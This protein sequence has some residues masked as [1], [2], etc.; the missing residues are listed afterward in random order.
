L[1]GVDALGYTAMSLSTLFA[2]GIFNRP[3]LETWLKWVFI[4]NGIIAPVILS[5]QIYPELAYAGATWIITLPS[6]SILLAVLFYRLKK[7]K[8]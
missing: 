2:A 5:T 6:S 3:G 4:M 1:T 8:I 7:Q